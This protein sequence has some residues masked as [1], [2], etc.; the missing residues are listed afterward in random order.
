LV[1]DSDHV[2]PTAIGQRGTRQFDDQSRDLSGV[3]L[4]FTGLGGAHA[5][6][7]L[8]DV[9]HLAVVVHECRAH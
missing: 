7:L 6:A 8:V 2:A 9:S 5:Q 4:H 3:E 1:G